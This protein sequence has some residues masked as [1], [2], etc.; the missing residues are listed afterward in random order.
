MALEARPGHEP[1]RD[2]LHARAALNPDSTGWTFKTGNTPVMPH[3]STNFS[4]AFDSLRDRPSA[5]AE[6]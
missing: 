1:A 3:D 4:V 5:R 6:G 2:L